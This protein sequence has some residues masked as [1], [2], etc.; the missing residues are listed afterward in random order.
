MELIGYIEK[1]GII[2]YTLLV[3]LTLGLTT[4]VWKYF[5]ILQSTK[6]RDIILQEIL[7]NV[8]GTTDKSL[9][10][11]YVKSSLDEKMGNLESGL[12]FIKTIATLAPL[13]GLLGTVIGIL[14][15][16]ETIASSGMGDT[17]TFAGGISLALVTTI[18]GL[19]ISIPHY[20]GYNFLAHKLDTLE[21]QM[22]KE[23]DSIL[24]GNQ[25]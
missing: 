4:I 6:N 23:A 22:S 18:M 1:G 2:G 8:K 10:L 12:G 7:A 25:R 21:A 15:A 20:V 13:L 9:T 3:M 16:F 17:G 19:I 14:V 11:N 24:I 5:Q